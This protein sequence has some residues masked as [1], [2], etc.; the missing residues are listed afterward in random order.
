MIDLSKI[1]DRIPDLS[2][3][4]EVESGP[5]VTFYCQTEDY[6]A[7]P[8]PTPAH[9]ATPEWFQ[10]IPTELGD[11]SPNKWSAK[12]CQPM[13]DAMSRG[14]ILKTPADLDI[15]ANPENNTIGVRHK[16]QDR[17]ISSTT[18]HVTQL[19]DKFPDRGPL[20]DLILFQLKVPW[21]AETADGYSLFVLPPLNRPDPRFRAFA[22]IIDTDN[23]PRPLNA[24]LM[25]TQPRYEG[26]IEKGTPFATVLPVKRDELGG[27]AEVRAATEEDQLRRER[28]KRLVKDSRTNKGYHKEVWQVKP[29]PQNEYE[30]DDYGV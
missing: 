7:F 19:G 9:E 24:V 6:G 23:Y 15:K 22:G 27:T 5:K 25:W 4:E 17:W 29:T 10:S 13:Y 8:P 20:S 2:D 14:W 16:S 11:E 30:D 21:T 3:H 18:N 12:A 26:R 1:T 28:H